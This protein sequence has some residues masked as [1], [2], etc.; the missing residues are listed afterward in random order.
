MGKDPQVTKG[1]MARK[2]EPCKRV[3]IAG[4]RRVPTNMVQKLSLPQ[5][6]VCANV[7]Y[8]TRT[9]GCCQHAVIVRPG[10]RTFQNVSKKER[11]HD[12]LKMSV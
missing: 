12:G 6:D 9:F 2:K 3:P 5:R 7:F 1:E 4:G 11:D 8:V 10:A